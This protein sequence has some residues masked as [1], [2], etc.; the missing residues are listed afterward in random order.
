M[1]QC[2][3]SILAIG[4]LLV[5]GLVQ[6]YWT[7]RW[8]S[9]NDLA[10][11]IERMDN[12]PLSL[13]DWDGHALQAKTNPRGT[14]RLDRR[15]VNRVTGESIE[16]T[17]LVGRPGPVSLETPD[18]CSS[19][20]G[21][22]ITPQGLTPLPGCEERFYTLDAVR[23][24]TSEQ[25]RLRLYGAWSTGSGW[26]ATPHPGLQCA[27]RRVLYKLYVTGDLTDRANPSQPDPCLIFLRELLPALNEILFH[28]VG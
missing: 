6:G 20:E 18:V 7:D 27:R 4:L 11:A 12:L 9:P 28:E 26:E 17:L 16:M 5:G 8:A 2:V 22:T 23:N 13:G 24:W 25:S 14:N 3:C 15:Y 19:A 10:L 1:L 21:Y